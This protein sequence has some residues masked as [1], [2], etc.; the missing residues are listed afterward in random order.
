MNL[1]GTILENER[2]NAVKQNQQL[3]RRKL[4]ELVYSFPK[5]ITRVLNATDVRVTDNLPSAVLL[6]VTI[7][8]LNRNSKLREAIAKMLLEMDGYL[9]ANGDTW[10]AIGGALSAVGSV[11]SGIGR[12]QSS[13]PEEQAIIAQQQEMEKQLEQERARRQRTTWVVIG[14]SVVALIA[15]FLI[16]RTMGKK[17]AA[18]AADAAKA[19]QIAVS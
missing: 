10:S 17:Q 3:V 11:L 16:Y 12:S 15:G 7:K 2:K 5:E 19:A 9:S 13:T 6:A 1:A 18:K 4:S 8:Y 14:I